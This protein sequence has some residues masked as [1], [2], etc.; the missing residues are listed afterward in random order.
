MKVTGN[1]VIMMHVHNFCNCGHET[2]M[3]L[4][5]CWPIQ[6][7]PQSVLEMHAMRKAITK[8]DIYLRKSNNF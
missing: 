3:W 5:F 1:F 4:I 2:R 6:N 8:P 7:L